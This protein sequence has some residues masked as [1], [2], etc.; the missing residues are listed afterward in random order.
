MSGASERAVCPSSNPPARG[1]KHPFLQ[2]PPHVLG[3]EPSEHV[4]EEQQLESDPKLQLGNND[5]HAHR[6]RLPRSS[7]DHSLS[8]SKAH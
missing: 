1:G 8:L 4:L 3:C 2:I 7:S 5:T 6:Y